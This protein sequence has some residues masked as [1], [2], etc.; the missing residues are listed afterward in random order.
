MSRWDLASSFY[1]LPIGCFLACI[2]LSFIFLFA[3]LEQE[4]GGQEN[5]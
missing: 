1:Y 4:N 3:G 5:K 2:S